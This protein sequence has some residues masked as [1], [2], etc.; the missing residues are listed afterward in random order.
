MG[1]TDSILAGDARLILPVAFVPDILIVDPPYHEHVHNSAS[2]Q[3]QYTDGGV[4]HNDFGFDA[5]TADL[6]VW[7]CRLAART[8]RWSV[9][10]TDIE[11]VASWKEELELA[12]AMYIRTLPWVRWSM[13]QL[14][15]DRPPQGFECLV[16]AHG[17]DRGRKH[18]NGAG[19][20]THLAHLALRGNGKHKT[21]KPLDQA[22][23]LVSWFSDPGELVVDPCA[24]SG[25]TGLACKILGRK[26]L[27]SELD[28][29]WAGKG[30]ARIQ[31]CDPSNLPG[32]LSARDSERFLRWVTTPEKE[33]SDLVERKY[34]TERVRK[35]MADKKMAL[36]IP[37]SVTSIEV[38][39][40]GSYYVNGK[41][42]ELKAGD[43][44]PFETEPVE[45]REEAMNDAWTETYQ[46]CVAELAPPLSPALRAKLAERKT[47]AADRTLPLFEDEYVAKDWREAYE[48]SVAELDEI[49]VPTWADPQATPKRVAPGEAIPDP[50]KYLPGGEPKHYDTG[51][52]CLVTTTIPPQNGEAAKRGKGRPPGARNKAPKA[53]KEAMARAVAELGVT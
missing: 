1:E 27:G 8:R 23:D 13:P 28:A 20:L 44:V 7:I 16:V 48:R 32:S 5:R 24:G 37:G 41:I 22:L 3:D 35:R 53:W 38:V 49:P 10:Y 14:S 50:Y 12:G 30:N 31:S 36:G 47:P 25:T 46:R 19:N 52:G 51:N 2:S 45:Q 40:P 26:F 29:E 6:Q 11:S 21:E 42:M 15:G 39:A 33:K 43:R 18:W 4:R 34:N 17:S 9:I